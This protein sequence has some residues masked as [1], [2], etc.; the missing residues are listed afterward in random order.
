MVYIHDDVIVMRRREIYRVDLQ[1]VP[2]RYSQDV[3]LLEGIVRS[4]RWVPVKPASPA[5]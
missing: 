3:K 4:W 1:T 5:S 2:E